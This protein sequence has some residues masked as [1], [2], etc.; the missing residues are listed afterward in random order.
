[1]VLPAA[2]ALAEDQ[3]ELLALTPTQKQALAGV[4]SWKI[5]VAEGYGGAEEYNGVPI[6]EDCRRILEY[7]GWQVVPAGATS[8]DAVLAIDVGGRPHGAYYGQPYAGSGEFSYSGA[9]VTI[10]ASVQAHGKP[11]VSFSTSSY[12][13]PCPSTIFSHT[14]KPENAP[15]SRAYYDCRDFF[16]Q[17]FSV[18]HAARGAEPIERAMN[19]S[20]SDIRGHAFSFVGLVGDRNFTPFLVGLLSGEQGEQGWSFTTSKAR[21]AMLGAAQA[22][23][24]LQDARGVEPL[25]TVLLAA[26]DMDLRLAAAVAL[27]QIGDPRALEALSQAVLVG[28]ESDDVLQETAKALGEL[29]GAA[30]TASLER[31]LA[32]HLEPDVAAA[33]AEALGRL[34]WQPQTDKQKITYHL[35]RDDKD[36]VVQMGR[37]AVPVLLENLKL[38]R[39]E[40]RELSASLLGDIGDP[41][42]VDPLC[43]AVLGDD[44]HDVRTAAAQALGKLR[45]RRAAGPLGQTLLTDDHAVVRIAAAEALGEISGPEAIASLQRALP[46]TAGDPATSGAVADALGKLHWQ[47]ETSDQRVLYH[48]VRDEGEE[49]VRMGAEAVPHLVEGLEHQSWERRQL[50]ASLLG[51]IGDPAAVDPLCAAVLG[52]DDYDVR[53]AAAGA[54]GWIRS[55]AALQ[56]LCSALN[57]DNSNIRWAAAVAL[58]RIGDRQAAVALKARLENETDRKVRKALLDAVEALGVSAEDLSYEDRLLLLARNKDWKGL[59]AFLAEQTVERLIAALKVDNRLVRNTAAYLLIDRTGQT[60]LGTDHDAWSEWWKAQGQTTSNGIEEE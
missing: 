29:G 60:D 5:T 50:S 12:T 56:P 44:D 8:F 33:V 20:D 30:A 43:A 16:T 26:E 17:L 6:A 10:D 36:A 23:G 28:D 31:A 48:L 45:D 53:V 14:S 2:P 51:K 47:P 32:M 19:D 22:L 57:D 41:E 46:A 42:A 27:R 21:P 59:N 49:I 58:A 9:T 52:D 38:P 4:K 11:L 18:V 35:A 24:D 3:S 55:S 37:K 15:F 40:P 34:D 13:V 7:A 25:C 1:M 54:L 39:W